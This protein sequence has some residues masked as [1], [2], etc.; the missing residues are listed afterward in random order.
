MSEHEHCEWRAVWDD[1]Q[2][3]FINEIN[4]FCPDCG[5]PIP[6]SSAPKPEMES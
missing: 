5:I 6:S 3:R 2:Q 4:K 1:A